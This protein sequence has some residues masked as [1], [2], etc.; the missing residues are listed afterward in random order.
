MSQANLNTAILV[1]LDANNKR[2]RKRWSSIANDV[3]ERLPAET[4]VVTYNQPFDVR[5]CLDNLINFKGVKCIIS[6]GGDGSANII[7]N[8]ILLFPENVRSQLYLGFIGLGSSN[9][10]LKPS[11]SVINNI[12]IKIN[13]K[14]TIKADITCATFV[15][16][17][18]EIKDR[19]FLANSSIGVGAYANW[20]FNKEDFV[21]HFLKSRL[22]KLTIYYTTIK[23]IF[24]YKNH[25]LKV[26]F[27]GKELDISTSYLVVLKNPHIAGDLKFDQDIKLDDGLLGLNICEGMGKFELIEVMSDLKKG[28]FQGKP[29][30]H[31]YTTTDI[32]IASE[33]LI[34]IEMD[35][36]IELAKEIRYTLLPRTL[37]ILQ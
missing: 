37:N 4:I 34:P 32:S 36:E 14:N 1:N 15:N 29:K 35:G 21:I 26:S 9:D 23:T 3:L 13:L 28:N 12:P 22:P 25:D 7:L 2:A 20:L 17:K 16:K 11:N 19:Y 18:D 24:T 8:E 33:K 10:I 5:K 30:R 6:A 27:N 31:S